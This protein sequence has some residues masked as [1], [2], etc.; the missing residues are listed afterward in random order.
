MLN[1]FCDHRGLYEGT[2]LVLNVIFFERHPPPTIKHQRE[3]VFQ[4]LYIYVFKMTLKLQL[5][6][7]N[8]NE[9]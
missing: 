3:D 4:N 6:F 9:T 7:I 1:F 5:K 2:Q 8:V